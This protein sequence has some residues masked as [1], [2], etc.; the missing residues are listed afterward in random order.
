MKTLSSFERSWTADRLIQRHSVA[1]QPS[2]DVTCRSASNSVD[3]KGRFVCIFR[4]TQ[5]EPLRKAVAQRHHVASVL[6]QWR[7]QQAR[8]KNRRCHFRGRVISRTVGFLRERCCLFKPAGC[9]TIWDF[10]NSV[11]LLEIV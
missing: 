6:E 10:C 7:L 8:Y 2:F 3:P 5:L 1:S 11:G 4:V 9:L